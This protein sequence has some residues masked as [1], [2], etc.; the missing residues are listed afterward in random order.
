VSVADW[1]LLDDLEPNAADL[2]RAAMRPK[3]YRRS[4]VLFWE[5]DPGSSLHL[6]T[7]GAVLAEGSTLDGDIIAY[8]VTGPGEVMG[9]MALLHDNEVRSAT[10]RAI[11][12]PATTLELPRRNLLRM[13]DEHPAVDRFLVAVLDQRVRRLSNLLIEF[14]HLS[15]HDRVRTR[16]VELV[17]TFG[18]NIP[19]SQERLASMTFTTRPTVNEVLQELRSDGI[20][21]LGRQKIIVIDQSQ[22]APSGG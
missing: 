4:E 1:A 20:I 8:S 5:G 19:L 6:V 12:G 9:E 14:R 10:A 15:A 2:I 13:R 18:V 17:D 11:G 3:K 16:L 22:L 7:S 21:D